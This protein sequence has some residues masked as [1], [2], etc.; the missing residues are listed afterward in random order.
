MPARKKYESLED[1]RERSRLYMEA[2]AIKRGRHPIRRMG[3]P[4]LPKEHSPVAPTRYHYRT[5]DWQRR[6]DFREQVGLFPDRL[7][8][9][10]DEEALVEA[11]RRER[12][13]HG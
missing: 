7:R 1:F 3:R 9:I 13:A 12:R 11:M 10:E 5:E 6:Q 4:S 2:R 8:G